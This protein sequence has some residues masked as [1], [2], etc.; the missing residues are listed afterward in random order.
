[1]LVLLVESV[2]VNHNTCHQY[3]FNLTLFNSELFC[4]FF[5]SLILFHFFPILLDVILQHRLQHQ[6]NVCVSLCVS[7]CRGVETAFA[8]RTAT[9]VTNSITEV[10]CRWK[11]ELVPMVAV[12]VAP[13]MAA[14]IHCRWIVCSHQARR[15]LIHQNGT[16]SGSTRSWTCWH[17]Y[18]HSNRAYCPSWINSPFYGL[19]YPTCAPKATFNVSLPVICLFQF[20]SY[21]FTGCTVDSIVFCTSGVW[22]WRISVYRTLYTK[23]RRDQIVYNLRHLA[24]SRPNV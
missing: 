24:H 8:W 22:M 1:M 7:R 3:L 21:L 23:F 13:E 2:W 12:A 19:V 16:V 17:H 5:F 9:T 20:D 4:L 15:R 6:S 18:C 11:T 10:W 14:R